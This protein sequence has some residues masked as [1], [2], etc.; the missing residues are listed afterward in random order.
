MRYTYAERAGVDRRGGQIIEV[1]LR[2]N[3][4]WN[5]LK[6]QS[7][8]D[9]DKT[10]NQ[11]LSPGI[12]SAL[13]VY[14]CQPPD[15]VDAEIAQT[16]TKLQS[17]QQQEAAQ[18]KALQQTQTKAAEAQRLR[19]EMDAIRGRTKDAEDRIQEL[20][21]TQGPLDK[22]AIQK[23]KDEKRKLAADHQA[24]RKQLDALSKAAKEAQ[25]RQQDIN[26]TRLSK[27]PW[28]S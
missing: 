17:Q 14:Q 4:A 8:G 20:E 1:K 11:S 28:P 12:K 24:K 21:N 7:A 26:K 15:A 16:N 13:G 10:L 27:A 25:K 22:E 23:L 9:T 5:R 19:R 18:L 6:T 2:R 3:L